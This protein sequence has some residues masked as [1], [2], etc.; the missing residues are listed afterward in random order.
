MTT[1]TNAE[2]AD[3]L[4]IEANIDLNVADI[5]A[6]HKIISEPYAATGRLLSEAARRLR[7][8]PDA[9][10]VSH[11]SNLLAS[12]CVNSNFSPIL[13]IKGNPFQGK[14]REDVAKLIEADLRRL[15]PNAFTEDQPAT[16]D[17]RAAACAREIN[18]ILMADEVMEAGVAAIIAR[19]YAQPSDEVA[20]LK[21]ELRQEKEHHEFYRFKVSDYMGA[22]IK[23]QDAVNNLRAEVLRLKAELEELS[24]GHNEAINQLR[25]KSSEVLRLRADSERVSAIID[26]KWSVWVETERVENKHLVSEYVVNNSHGEFRH[27]DGR[28]AIDAALN[29]PAKEA[30]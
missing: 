5:H 27:I 20:R 8:M 30:K 14:Q 24:A 4:Q 15:R 13:G 7:A 25:S 2:L 6:N 17:E 26:G 21:G 19:H 18:G 28:H 16:P 3:A 23:W 12:Y 10:T 22:E 29:P 11:F 9:M 1:K